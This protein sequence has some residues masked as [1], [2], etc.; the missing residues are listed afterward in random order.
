V[1]LVPYV[2]H[3]EGYKVNNMMK[4][5]K[6]S[7]VGYIVLRR[8]V[9]FAFYGDLVGFSCVAFA[10]SIEDTFQLL[11]L[12]ALVEVSLQKLRPPLPPLGADG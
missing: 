5:G 9:L 8:Q 11:K 7:W 1:A 3:V 12:C 4:R 2:E 10:F 6:P